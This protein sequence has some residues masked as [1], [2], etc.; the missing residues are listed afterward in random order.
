MTKH[1]SQNVVGPQIRR[2]RVRAGMTQDFLAAKCGV[3]GWDISRATLSKIEAGVR[4]VTDAE[5]F[6][7]ARVLKVDPA[8]LFPR[9]V[10]AVLA[11]LR[12][13]AP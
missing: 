11:L 9:D 5:L 2:L 13:K 3:A 10:A 1:A 7:V 6:L 12:G 8:A 4:C